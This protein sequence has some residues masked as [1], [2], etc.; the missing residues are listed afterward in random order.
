MRPIV[1]VGAVIAL[2]GKILLEQ[3]KNEPGRGK[4]SVPGGKVE[5]GETPEQTVIRET[6]EETG[7]VVDN[8][9]LI[10]VV[11]QVTLD[12]NGKVKYHFIIID[13]FVRLKSGKLEA[14][15]DAASLEWVPLGEVEN[16]DLTASFRNFFFENHESL[17]KMDSGT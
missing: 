12:E 1:G 4:W 9:V 8:P 17:K 2:K 5:L 13:Y 11:S 6:K 15:S 14:A 10:D 3:R 7:L 16:K